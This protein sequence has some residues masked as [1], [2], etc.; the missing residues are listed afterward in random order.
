MTCAGVEVTSPGAEMTCAGVEVTSEGEGVTCAG[1]EVKSADIEITSTGD[2]MT[3]TDDKVTSTGDE[4]TSTGDEV[5][6]TGVEMTSTDDKVTSTGV[7]MTSTGDK[8]TSTG[9]EMTSTGVEMT[10]AGVDRITAGHRAAVTD[11]GLQVAAAFTADASDVFMTSTPRTRRRGSVDAASP[12]PR[13]SPRWSVRRTRSDATPGYRRGASFDD[14][15]PGFRAAELLAAPCAGLT[16]VCLYV[17]GVKEMALVLLL[18]PQACSL[19]STAEAL[20]KLATAQLESLDAVLKK[21]L[22]N[23]SS[24]TGPDHRWLVYDDSEWSLQG[25]PLEPVY[26]EDRAFSNLAL[27][28]HGEYS[29]NENVN[30]VTCRTGHH[31]VVSRRVDDQETFLSPR[32]CDGKP[33]SSAPSL[34]AAHLQMELESGRLL[35]EEHGI[36]LL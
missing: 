3:S 33:F 1:V 28:L 24:Y 27:W 6:S 25:E 22:Q 13:G 7:E 9:V 34:S 12:A 20:Y 17:Q 31:H 19:Q 8:V 4:V 23:T 10:S 11:D 35:Q 32:Q 18:D 5:T 2:K 36:V 16:N 30:Q 15:Y 26:E 21:V 14:S 29:E